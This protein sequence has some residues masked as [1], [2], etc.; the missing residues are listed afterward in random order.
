MAATSR[1]GVPHSTQPS[2]ARPVRHVPVWS[3]CSRL[4]RIR[5]KNRHLGRR[6][7]RRPSGVIE[8][9]SARPEPLG[10]AGCPTA[11]VLA[12][13]SAIMIAL[14]T[15]GPARSAAAASSPGFGDWTACAACHTVHR[16]DP[17]FDCP[18]CHAPASPY[19]PVHPTGATAAR[20]LTHHAAAC[21]SCHNETSAQFCLRCHSPKASHANEACT[22]CHNGAHAARVDAA[23]ACGNCHDGAA[24]LPARLWCWQ[25]HRTAM[26]SATPRLT[27]CSSCHK[28][29]TGHA[30]GRAGCRSCHGRLLQQHHAAGLATTKTCVDCHATHA[31]LHVGTLTCQT[32]HR[33]ASHRLVLHQPSARRCRLCHKFRVAARARS[34]YRCHKTPVAHIDP[35]AAASAAAS[36]ASC[37]SVQP[38]AGEVGCGSCHTG[39]N[40]HL[41]RDAVAGCA[42]CHRG[43]ALHGAQSCR[44]CHKRL[45][46][47]N[48]AVASSVCRICHRLPHGT[49]A[50]TCTS[51]HRLHGG[52]QGD[53]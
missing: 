33:S 28:G 6:K 52:G 10:R 5:R 27:S 31:T 1:G 53:D 36:C 34:C 46:G 19:L 21:S 50:S 2:D 17:A 14:A 41:G 23:A 8:G 12:V 9:M 26:H 37:H 4:L 45:H 32:C 38:H 16:P 40:H 48:L 35:A 15:L 13:L 7:F 43:Y 20:P 18:T 51:C 42:S 49:R 47:T 3:G 11:L 44:S 29:K 22:V 25:C 30:G 39:T 24:S